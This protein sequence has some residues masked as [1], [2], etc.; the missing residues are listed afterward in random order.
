MICTGFLRSCDR[1]D[2]GVSA[3]LKGSLYERTGVDL[4]FVVGRSIQDI[5]AKGLFVC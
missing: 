4:S 2:E 3:L 5:A 1:I